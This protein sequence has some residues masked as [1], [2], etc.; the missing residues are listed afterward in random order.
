MGS[1]QFDT[2]QRKAAEQAETWQEDT[3]KGLAGCGVGNSGLD[4]YVL[5]SLWLGM[6]SKT[7][8]TFGKTDEGRINLS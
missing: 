6:F 1:S 7:E 8:E 2:M 5:L 3:E 4:F